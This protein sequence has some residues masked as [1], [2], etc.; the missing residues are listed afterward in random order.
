M[1][2]KEIYQQMC[3]VMAQRGG[4]Y[5]GIDIPEFYEMAEVLFAPE[6]AKINTILPFRLTTLDQ[7]APETDMDEK[8]V[9]KILEGMADKGLCFAIELDGKS[10]YS[11]LPFIPGIMEHQFM[12]GT[13]TELDRKIASVIHRYKKAVDNLVEYRPPVYSEGRVIPIDKTIETG[14][15]VH[16]YDQVLSYIDQNDYISVATC[17]CRHEAKLLDENDDCGKPD[18]VCMQF[19]I[20]A[21]YSVERGI[22]RKVSKREAEE[23]LLQAEE[24]GLIHCTTNIQDIFFICNCCTCHCMAIHNAL[25]DPKP[26]SIMSSGFLPV[27]NHDVCSACETCIE[28][29]PTTALSLNQDD[30]IDLEVDKCFGCGLCASNCDEVAILMRKKEGAVSPPANSKELGK[31][32]KEASRKQIRQLCV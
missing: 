4:P 20:S 17:Y 29:C 32:I 30:L 11:G 23:I 6:E 2:N 3:Q 19:G 28:V 22:A 12:R 25:V 14:K 31:K 13:K 18:E 16:T 1:N 21:R 15:R 5:P 7:I 26:A 24:A 9:E 8:E 27:T 10:Y